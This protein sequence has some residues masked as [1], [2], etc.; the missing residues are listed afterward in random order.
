[1]EINQKTKEHYDAVDV[2]MPVC[3]LWAELIISQSPF[4]QRRGEN[5]DFDD[6]FLFF[7]P[8]FEPSSLR[9]RRSE[10]SSASATFLP[11]SKGRD[12]REAWKRSDWLRTTGARP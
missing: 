12:A 10:L 4:F 6:L 11:T 5:V 7:R 3:E 2:H 9:P 8:L 1:M